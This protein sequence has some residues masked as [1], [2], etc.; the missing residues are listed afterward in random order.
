MYHSTELPPMPSTIGT[1]N[2]EY[3]VSYAVRSRW[4][5]SVN[6]ASV[7]MLGRL[8]SSYILSERARQT[9]LIENFLL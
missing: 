4:Q 7:N 8:R 2:F 1:D 5:D 9:R 3:L 6:K